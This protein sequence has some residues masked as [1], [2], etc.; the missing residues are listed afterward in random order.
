MVLSGIALL[1]FSG[2]GVSTVAPFAP[3]ASSA[4]PR[5]AALRKQ[6]EARNKA[7]VVEFWTSIAENHAPLI[8]P[9]PADGRSSLVTFVWRAKEETRNVVV[10]SGFSGDA[11]TP[12]L[13]TSSLPTIRCSRTGST[14]R[15]RPAC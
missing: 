3:A 15:I 4:S 7:A 9:D 13:P 8:E 12:V 6:V 10:Y 1:I 2:A 14:L 5:I 11:T